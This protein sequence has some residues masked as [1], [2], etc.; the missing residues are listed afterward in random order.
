MYVHDILCILVE[1][2]EIME[3]IQR[4]VNFKYDKIEEPYNYLGS[5]LANKSLGGT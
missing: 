3:K 1:A 5:R 2:Q 4:Y